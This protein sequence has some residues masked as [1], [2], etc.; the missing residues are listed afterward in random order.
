MA[1]LERN[2]RSM[3]DV[4]KMAVRLLADFG[5]SGRTLTADSALL[6]VAY[7]LNH[8]RLEARYLTASGEFE[9]RERLRHWLIRSLLKPGVW[10]SGLDSLLT[11]IRASIKEH[12][13]EQ[14][15]VDAIEAVM[16][17]RG[18]SLRFDKEE[19]EDL[20]EVAYPDKRVFS[21][22]TLLYP[23]VDLRNDF[24]ID[25]VFPRSR[26]TA[27]RLAKAG[28][29]ESEIDWYRDH[30]DRLAN[31]QLLEGAINKAK[32]DQLPLAWLNDR[33]R[34]HERRADYV[35]RHDLGRLPEHLSEFKQFYLAR[36]EQMANKLDTVL[37]K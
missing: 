24:H 14:F 22:L 5:F 30:A 34:D 36:R 11:A 18:R 7:Y 26:F 16:Q 20:A 9:D 29:Q 27:A 37:G 8:R 19:I 17:R 3:A 28:I 35:D 23:F 6:P 33:F 31:L 13:D 1:S 12:G 32:Q 25:H 4:L 2:W 10:G 21:L 15:P